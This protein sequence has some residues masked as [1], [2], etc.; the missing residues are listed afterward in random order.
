MYYVGVAASDDEVDCSGHFG[1]K[2]PTND[3]R[4]ACRLLGGVK[5]QADVA[6]ASLCHCGDASIGEL[7]RGNELGVPSR[8]VTV[9]FVGEVDDYF[10]ARTRRGLMGTN[11]T[12]LWRTAL[13]SAQMVN[14]G[15]TKDAEAE[16]RSG[17]GGVE[18]AGAVEKV[19]VGVSRG[20]VA[21]VDGARSGQSTQSQ[22]REK[23]NYR[24]CIEGLNDRIWT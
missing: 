3:T 1:P 20:G 8:S 14:W 24:E 11:S 23:P 18:E 2:P 7:P 21:D 16:T 4:L 9:L 19:R 22:H 5:T 12:G 17:V 6:P 10:C 13:G 15:Q